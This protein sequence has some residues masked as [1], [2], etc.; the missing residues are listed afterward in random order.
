MTTTQVGQRVPR[1]D[2]TAKA[3]GTARYASDTPVAGLL[4]ARLVLSLYAHARIVT[5]DISAAL[6]L[7][8]VVAVLTA[9]DLPLRE[10]GAGSR[11]FEPLARSE[12]VFAGQPVAMVIAAS[13]AAA[14]DGVDLV[15]VTYE[16]LVPVVDLEDAFDTAS[17][18][19]RVSGELGSSDMSLHT[20]VGA[21]SET[22]SNEKLSGNVIGR[23][24]HTRG[25]VNTAF[26]SCAAVVEGRFR[27]SWIHQSYLEPQVAVAWVEPD[28]CLVMHASTQGHFYSRGLLARLFGLPLSKIRV[29]GS[30][31]GGAFGG[32]VGL[33]EPLVGA[34]ALAIG[35]PVR[36][37]FTRSEDFAAANPAPSC[38]ID[39]RIGADD[40]GKLRAIS[41][42][43]LTDAG[44]FPEFGGAAIAAAKLGGAYAWPAWRVHSYG[45]VT[46]RFGAGAYR[47]PS[48]TPMAFAL[49]SL[50]DEL[51]A[52]LELDALELRL[53]NVPAEGDLRL[54]GT[55]WP[56][57]GLTET[58][59]AIRTHPLWV[60]RH[61]LPSGEGV[62]LA[63]G[64]FPGGKQGAGASC[65]LQTDGT[66]IV[67]IGAV[68][69]TGTSTAFAA[70]AAETLGVAVERVEIKTP[71][72]DSAPAALLS[73]GSMV[74]YSVGPAVQAAALQVRTQILEI[75]GREMEVDI[76]DLEIADG[77]VRPKGVPTR[78]VPLA[79]IA[80]KPHLGDHRRVGQHVQGHAQSAYRP[81]HDQPVVEWRCAVGQ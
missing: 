67:S 1:I 8:G 74:T 34:A 77:I 63:V 12:V 7:P 38:V 35:Q 19:A 48:A 11:A 4:H 56:A 66:F 69:M 29:V 21:S 27:T 42:R 59:E 73:A 22:D 60:H 57:L 45:V 2:G 80:G 62:G 23:H 78:G 28:G 52:R 40:R 72:T 37:A 70:I 43:I 47:A 5:I 58:L 64:L 81:L 30:T 51:A 3:T 26:A 15:D 39:V 79:E 10:G 24:V 71:D 17:P 50:V 25:D 33:I 49:E 41:A 18:L 76:R 46:N 36:L 44:A 16:P 14:E 32:K 13:E 75:A 53:R 6:E 61:A 55:A 68:D 9:H 20:E 31:L 65:R 54:D